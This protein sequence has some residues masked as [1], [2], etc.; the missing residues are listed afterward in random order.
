MLAGEALALLGLRPLQGAI[1]RNF[2]LV[3]GVDRNSLFADCQGV[4][5]R[6]FFQLQCAFVLGGDVELQLVALFKL[7]TPDPETLTQLRALRAG[8]VVVLQVGKRKF[9]RVAIE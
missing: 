1:G 3:L 9:A 8:E 5:L 6:Q 2:C 7:L 4:F